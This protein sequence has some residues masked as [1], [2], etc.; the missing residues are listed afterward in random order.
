MAHRD[1][2]G[3]HRDKNHSLAL[4]YQ[5]DLAEMLAHLLHAEEDSCRESYVVGFDVGMWSAT[6]SHNWQC[7]THMR[8]GFRGGRS[9]GNVEIFVV[10]R[11]LAHPTLHGHR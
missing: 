9:A 8:G 2:S 3:F 11:C 5:S 1:K 10:L 7:F 6:E 4:M